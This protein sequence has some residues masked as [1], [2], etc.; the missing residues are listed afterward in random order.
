MR[1]AVSGS[2][3]LIG[4]TL[5]GELR[6]AG[7]SVSRLVRA[8][9]PQSSTERLIAWN[10][11]RGSIDAKGLEGHDAVVHLAGASIFALWTRSRKQ[12]IRDSRIRGTT[13][14]ARTLAGLQPPPRLLISASA[15]GY[16]GNRPPTESVDETGARGDGFLAELAQQWED[17]A[18][19]AAA[20]GM[21]V[22]NPRF[23]L[24]LTPKGG[25]LAV[26]LPLFQFGL[27]GKLGSGAQIWSWIT[28]PDLIRGITHILAHDTLQGPVNFTAP[29]AVSNETFTRVL[30]R[31]LKRP[32]VFTVPAFAARFLGRQMAE[33]L[34]LS[35][36][37][38]VPRKL[39]DSNFRFLHAE[40]EPA[41][42]ALVAQR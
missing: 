8:R 41:L 27:G 39:I 34:L 33:E 5:V 10:P 7:H 2:S 13:L 14:L 1:I 3:G 22:V 26:M 38:A 23:G 29:G 11:A 25:A 42:A 30:G 18:K 24:V 37:R 9:T 35:G 16:Y 21:R 4:S 28:L 40:L 6:S 32:T 17:A 12:A 36:V 31:V 19:P 15:V 20:A